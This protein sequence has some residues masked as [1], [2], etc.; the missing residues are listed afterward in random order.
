[1]PNANDV[2]LLQVAVAR[3]LLNQSLAGACLSEIV[4]AEREGRTVRAAQVLLR[5]QALTSDQILSLVQSV[6]DVAALDQR[7]V[8]EST[9]MGM[10]L[11]GDEATA[12]VKA[13]DTLGG[14]T[15]VRELARG[16][17]GILFE[18]HHPTLPPAA[19]KVLSAQAARSP[20]VVA[21]F[22]QEAQLLASLEH[23]G[24]VKVRSCDY[25]R[26]A[27]YLAMDYVQGRSL[28]DLVRPGQ[29][30]PKKA[31]EVIAEVA[32][33]CA[34]MHG[35]GVVHRDIKPANIMVAS[36]G[37]VLL[38]DFGLAKDTLRRDIIATQMGKFIGTPAYMA[39]EQARGDPAAIGP[40]TDV[41]ALG[42]VLFRCITGR[43]PFAGE[44]FLGTVAK[45]SSED[46]PPITA[47]R[48][49]APADLDQIVRA[50]MF[51]DPAARP[52]A[53]QVAQAIAAILARGP[54]LMP[55]APPFEQ[56]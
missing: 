40:W 24:L 2:R 12:Q 55:P 49:D 27:H 45:I 37:R 43:Y 16:A 15:L 32:R 17:V 46:A 44:S 8:G 7:V 47:Y 11:R 42:A 31:L 36:G 1:M 5:R 20:E 34:Y 21:R 51:R 56:V 38:V 19:I 3:G 35:R 48:P 39:P 30:A 23:P 22:R 14:Y 54:L 29:L 25:D 4:A 50:A 28:A 10:V 33:T 9:A 13:G 26:G 6:Q 18:G 41:Y 52:S 53:M